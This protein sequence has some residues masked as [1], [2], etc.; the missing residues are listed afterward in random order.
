MAELLKLDW[1]SA[2][3]ED[4]TLTV[5]LSAQP[6]KKWREAF[7]GTAVLL[8]TRHWKVA[9]DHKKGTVRVS[10]V[11]PGDEDELRQ[12]LEGSVLQ[13][14][15]TLVDEDELFGIE[16]GEREDEDKEDSDDPGT[17]STDEGLTESFRAFAA[18]GEAG[19]E[20]Q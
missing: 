17:G 19:E 1:S 5:A 9:L 12:L 13:A 4:G 10:A 15:A 6:P 2:T 18:E 7:E 20:E 16:R 3:V 14:N 11:Q 8:D